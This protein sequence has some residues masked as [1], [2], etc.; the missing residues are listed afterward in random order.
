M[1]L[2]LLL[3][4]AA[5]PRSS[6]VARNALGEYLDV[7]HLDGQV[8]D[9]AVLV[10][11]E[12]VTNAVLHGTQPIYLRVLTTDGALRIEVS[13][14]TPSVLRVASQLAARSATG[15]RG[16]FIVEALSECWGETPHE[17]NGKTIWAEIP[18]EPIL[19]I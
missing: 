8:K 13:D 6:S 18:L 11:S 14:C 15:G 17:G 10:V 4:L 2:E 16:L 9:A 12:L 7:C 5:V 3:P 19:P 1:A